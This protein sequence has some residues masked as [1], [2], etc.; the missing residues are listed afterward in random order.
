MRT[1][2]ALAVTAL[3][4]ASSAH[5]ADKLDI[6]SEVAGTTNGVSNLADDSFTWN[7]Q[8]F[9]GFYYDPKKDIGTEQ[10]TISITDEN[11]L[12]GSVPF[13]V[14]YTTTACQSAFQLSDFGSYNVIG[15]LGEKYFAGYVNDTGLYQWMQ[16]PLLRSDD[17]N[18]LD[19]GQLQKILMDDNS[20]IVVTQDKPLELLE[21][22]QL[23]FKSI[24]SRSS[25]VDLE[26]RKDGVVVDTSSAYPSKDDATYSDKTYTYKKDLGDQKGLVTIA[27]YIKNAYNDTETSAITVDGIWQISEESTAVK[28][29]DKFGKMSVGEADGTAGIITLNNAGQPISLQGN[30]DVPLMG[31]IHLRTADSNALRL[32]LYRQV[33]E[34]GTYDIRGS[35]AGAIDKTDNLVEGSFTWSPQNF[36][37]FYYDADRDLGTES[38]TTTLTEGN[39]LSGDSPYGISY[40]T[41][42]QLAELQF[43]DWGRYLIIGF[44]GEPYFAGYSLTEDGGMDLLNWASIDENSLAS[45]QLERILLDSREKTVLAKGDFLD[46]EEGYRLL[47]KGVDDNGKAFLELSKDGATVNSKIIAPGHEYANTADQTYYY[48]TNVGVQNGLVT[49][50]VHFKDAVSDGRKSEAIVDGIWQISEIPVLV[51]PDKT[52]GKMLVRSVDASNG[53]ITMDNKDSALTLNKNRDISLLPE[54]GLRT[55]DNDT[56]RFF[57][58]R[59]GKF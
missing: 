4:L 28:V 48:R 3:L 45:G 18:S 55:A 51:A 10:L 57:I 14:V 26:L 37:G 58:Y 49:I 36:A 38:L 13:G 9:P 40:Q 29:G 52:F 27:V 21:G 5:A 54:I 6:R 22:Y 31:D 42:A 12:S 19:K 56:L 53:V 15:F 24:D 35:I 30:S 43:Q 16:I 11:D 50:A 7:P 23:G 41:V 20:E 34:P 47:L 1:I 17:P 44:L 25:R 33:T 32:Y 59:Q 2:L 46:L 8:N 39:W